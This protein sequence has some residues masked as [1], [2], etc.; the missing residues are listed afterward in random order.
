MQAV[1]HFIPQPGC[2]QAFLHAAMDVALRVF[3]L[4]CEPKSHVIKDAFGEWIRFLKNQTYLCPDFGN[5]SFW[6][7]DILF[8][9]HDSTLNAGF[10]YQIV[11]PV[12]AAEQGR[13][14][15]A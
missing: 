10:R 5:I 7:V 15:A 1:F 2:F 9:Q 13:F 3:A 14:T 11:H 12:K 4:D 8:S 6:C